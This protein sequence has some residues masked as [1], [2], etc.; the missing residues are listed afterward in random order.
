MPEEDKIYP[1]EVL[2]KNEAAAGTWLWRLT[3]PPSFQFRGGQF[4][5]L[6]IPQPRFTDSRGNSRP[7]SIAS[8]PYEPFLLLGIRRGISAF[9]RNLELI[10]PGDKLQIRGPWGYFTLNEKLGEKARYVFLAAGTGITPIRSIIFQAFYEKYWGEFWLFYSNRYPSSSLFL[11]EFQQLKNPHF[12]FIPTMTRLK[13][14]KEPWRGE[15]GRINYSLLARYLPTWDNIYYLVGPP[16]FVKDM[17]QL[18][19]EQ[20]L[21]IDKIKCEAW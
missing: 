14:K 16:Q 15:R 2:A 13:E 6:I 21:T 8:A 3:K 20:G 4:I 10:K 18:L 9:K 11:D 19:L 7:I 17:R 12:H 1:V 5:H